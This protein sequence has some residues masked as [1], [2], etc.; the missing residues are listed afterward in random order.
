MV[1]GLSHLAAIFALL[2]LTAVGGA[3]ATLPELHRKIVENLS[4][5]DDTTFV[6]LVAMAQLAPGPNVIVIS[7]IGW[8]LAGASGLVIA[9]L[10]MVVPSSLLALGA[11]RIMTHYLLS[12]GLI[13][14]KQALAPIATGLM[15]SSGWIM[16]EATG[17]GPLLVMITGGM[18]IFMLATRVNPL[19]GMIGSALLAAA[20]A[21]LGFSI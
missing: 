19:W 3:N 4:L 21:G 13:L 11:E 16:A 1:S 17:H 5:M 12:S 10:A 20:G 2:S 14:L 8:H 7:M 15:L 9:T 18:V 6:N